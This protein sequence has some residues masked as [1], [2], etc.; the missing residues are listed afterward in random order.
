MTIKQFI[1]DFKTQ[2]A[3]YNSSGLIDDLSVFSWVYRAL[4]SFGN[5]IMELQDAVVE[6]KN[7]RGRL[8]KGFHDLRSAHLC[9]PSGYFTKEEDM[10]IIQNTRAWTERQDSSFKWELC[11]ECYREKREN[12]VVEKTYINAREICFYYKKSKPLYLAKHIKKSSFIEEYRRASLGMD[13]SQEIS[14]NGTTMYTNFKDGFVYIEFFGIPTNE[15]GEMLIPE[16]GIGFIEYIETYVNHRFYEFLLKNVN[17]EK[18]ASLFQLYSN[19]LP[20][21]RGTAF[22]EVKFAGLTPSSFRKMALKN[23]ANIQKFERRY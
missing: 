16:I 15:N 2:N 9:T 3:S 14:V 8:P 20:I 5:D 18:V 10:P 23:R 22:T 6:I 21:K 4:T 7:G 1:A 19:Q 13:N 12:L 17:D 11:N